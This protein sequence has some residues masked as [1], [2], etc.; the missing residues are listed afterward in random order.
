MPA[1]EVCVRVAFQERVEHVLLFYEVSLWAVWRVGMTGELNQHGLFLE[2]VQNS[3][4][5]E[6]GLVLVQYACVLVLI[7]CYKRYHRR[8]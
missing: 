4:S 5:N 3:R 1:P 8:L 7:V 2:S 6:L